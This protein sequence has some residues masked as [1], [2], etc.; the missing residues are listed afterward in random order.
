LRIRRETPALHSGNLKMMPPKDIPDNILSYVR[1]FNDEREE[2]E[3]YIFLNFSGETASVMPPIKNPELL[4]STTIKSNPLQED[5]EI[6]LT[7]WE[8]IVL[9]GG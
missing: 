2:Q 7:P 5:G 8:G 3:V 1:S 6:V 4:T 9:K